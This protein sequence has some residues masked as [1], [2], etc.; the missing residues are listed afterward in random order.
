MKLFKKVALASLVLSLSFAMV[1]CDDDTV[2]TV[3]DNIGAVGEKVEN[4]ATLFISVGNE[5]KEIE[6]EYEGELTA[7]ALIQGISDVTGWDLTLSDVVT[8]GAGG[9]SVTFDDLSALSTLMPPDEQVEEFFVY[10]GYG[11]AES[12]LNSVTETLQNNFVDSELG[13]PDLLDVYF[14]INDEDIEVYDVEIPMDEPWS[15]AI[16]A[17]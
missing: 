1:G 3:T 15:G 9:M 4:I 16:T 17:E 5:I 13:D 14:S 12:I 2:S 10:D 6:F 7:E 8:S 11:L